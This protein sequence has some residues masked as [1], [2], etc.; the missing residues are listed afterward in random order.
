M[1][2]RTMIVNNES[3]V[4]DGE[5]IDTMVLSFAADWMPADAA[6]LS[7]DELAESLVDTRASNGELQAPVFLPQIV[8]RPSEWKARGDIE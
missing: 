6:Q 5:I 3:E 7:A 8:N 2:I 4:K 1:N